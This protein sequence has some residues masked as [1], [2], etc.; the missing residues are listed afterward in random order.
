MTDYKLTGEVCCPPFDPET[1]DNKTLSWE[2]KLFIKD[3]MP[4]F[5][6]IPWPP[7]IGKLMTRMRGKI[8]KA[9]VSPK[10]EDFICL[11]YDPTPWR[12]EYYMTVEKEIPDAENIKLSGTFI[13]KVFDGPYNSVPKFIKEMEQIAQEK[14]KKVLKNYFYYTS[15]PKCAKLYGHNYIVAFTQVEG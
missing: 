1:M 12:S 2:D 15:C 6:H 10:L 4:T 5:F 3:S 8:E 11:A 14:G 9:K 13:T 7:T